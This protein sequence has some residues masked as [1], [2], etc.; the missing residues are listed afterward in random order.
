MVPFPGAAVTSSASGSGA[1][2]WSAWWQ[3]TQSGGTVEALRI[4]TRLVSADQ[5]VDCF[6]VQETFSAFKRTS[7]SWTHFFRE[8]LGCWLGSTTKK[9]EATQTRSG[10]SYRKTWRDC[11]S[12]A[13]IEEKDDKNVLS[14]LSW[15]ISRLTLVYGR[16]VYTDDYWCGFINQLAT[17]GHQ[18]LYIYLQPYPNV[19]C[20]LVQ[21]SSQCHDVNYIH[22]HH[23]KWSSK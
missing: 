20:I 23:L 10:V 3:W 2:T 1:T 14:Q 12:D 17:G 21:A 13:F 6:R 8:F 18:N 5:F 11:N 16:H 9:V 15:F 19:C 22:D 7:Q 4:A